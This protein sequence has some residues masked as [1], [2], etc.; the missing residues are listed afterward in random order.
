MKE[1][2]R[3]LIVIGKLLALITCLVADLVG[4]IKDDQPTQK[5][6]FDSSSTRYRNSEWYLTLK[7]NIFETFRCLI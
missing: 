7:M 1:K 6:S 3:V 5:Y 2:K 4:I